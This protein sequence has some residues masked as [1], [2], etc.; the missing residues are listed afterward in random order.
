MLLVDALY[1]DVSRNGKPFHREGGDPTLRRATHGDVVIST[2]ASSGRDR[3]GTLFMFDQ[4]TRQSAVV[5]IG[6]DKRTRVV[7]GDAGTVFKLAGKA[8]RS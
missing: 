6:G 2:T 1:E 5:A 8:T 3:R 4:E 7:S